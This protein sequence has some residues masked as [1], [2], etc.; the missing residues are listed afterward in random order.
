MPIKFQQVPERDS[1]HAFNGLGIVK[2]RQLAYVYSEQKN[3]IYIFD[4]QQHLQEKL[5]AIRTG[6]TVYI[7][8][9]REIKSNEIVPDPWQTNLHSFLERMANFQ[10][11]LPDFTIF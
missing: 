1:L 6:N 9:G 10:S 4:Y 5:S 11:Y 3:K 8:D 7:S 2:E